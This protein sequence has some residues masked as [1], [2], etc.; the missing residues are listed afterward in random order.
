M[1][2]EKL[3]SLCEAIADISYIA[4]REEYRTEDS[5]EMIS[6]FIEWAKEFEYI[7]RH[8]NWGLDSP[9]DYADVI[10]Y[11]TIFKISVWRKI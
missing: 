9:T 5:R 4:G 11:F 8:M 7:H 1:K 10:Y 2:S 3:Y 6:Q